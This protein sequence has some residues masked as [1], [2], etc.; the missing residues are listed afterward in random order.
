MK[1]KNKLLIA[2]LAVIAVIALEAG[3]FLRN[4]DND[5]PSNNLQATVSNHAQSADNPENTENP[6]NTDSQDDSNELSGHIGVSK[7]LIGSKD[8]LT[9]PNT[10]QAPSVPAEKHIIAFPYTDPSTGLTF[11]TLSAYSGI[12]LEDGSDQSTDNVAV[13]VVQNTTGSDVEYASITLTSDDQTYTFEGSVI[14]K[15]QSIVLQEKNQ[16]SYDNTAFNNCD[17][18]TAEVSGFEQSSNCIFYTENDNGS[19][20]VT[21]TSSSM[22]PCVRVFY[23]FFMEDEDAYVGGITYNAKITDLSAGQTITITP[24]HYTSGFSK[25]V[26]VRTYDSAQ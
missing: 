20:S 25:V 2:L 10:I 15:G 9:D 13:L 8:K 3:L 16:K 5:S 21:N 26:M 4:V 11:S 14:P 6:E 17:A 1:S 22:I 24:S 7:P 23:K 18:Q 12:Y 19:I